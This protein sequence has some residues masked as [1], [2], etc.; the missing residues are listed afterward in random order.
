VSGRYWLALVEGD[1]PASADAIASV[2]ADDAAPRWLAAW[3]RDAKPLRAARR[4]DPAVIDPTGSAATVSISLPDRGQMTIFDDTAVQEARRRVLADPEPPD[5]LST[6]L[7]DAS[8]FAGSVTVRRGPDACRRLLDDPF[9][10]VAPVRILEVGPGLFGVAALCCG[11]TIERHGS[12]VPW[13][14]GRFGG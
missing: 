8:H 9:R 2:R 6:L 14:G 5:A 7:V 1:A 13:P 10:L 11:P 3:S 4:V 12:D